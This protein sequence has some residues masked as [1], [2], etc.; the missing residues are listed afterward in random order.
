M[1]AGAAVGGMMVVVGHAGA[2]PAVMYDV[3]S[4]CVHAGGG[5]GSGASAICGGTCR[6]VVSR[7]CLLRG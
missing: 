7:V 6:M 2:F 3:S 5:C 4:S 1:A